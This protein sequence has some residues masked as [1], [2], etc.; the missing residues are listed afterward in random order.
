ML[1]V[2]SSFQ[3]ESFA[4]RDHRDDLAA[5]VDHSFYARWSIGH[6]SQ[7]LNANNLLHG[8]NVESELFSANAKADELQEPVTILNRASTHLR[9]SGIYRRI[10]HKSC[11]S[12]GAP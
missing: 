8:K 12:T 5:Q 9:V 4:Q 2:G 3:S 11:H 1:V 10:G 6:A 7:A